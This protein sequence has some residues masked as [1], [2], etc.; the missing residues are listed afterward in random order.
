VAAE[1]ANFRYANL[2]GADL[3]GAVL[4]GANLR[5]ANVTDANF[6]GVELATVAMEFANF[7]KA[8][9]AQ[10]PSYKANLR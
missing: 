4:G 3:S 6:E 9:N 5:R 10:I 2:T 1:D 8:R 7:S